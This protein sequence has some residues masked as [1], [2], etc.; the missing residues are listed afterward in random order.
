MCLFW[1]IRT[2]KL[3]VLVIKFLAL[4]SKPSFVC[5]RLGSVRS[6]HHTPALRLVPVR[7]WQWRTLEGAHGP[8]GRKRENS[9]RAV[10][11]H[12][13]CRASPSWQQPVLPAAAARSCLRFPNICRNSFMIPFS[14]LHTSPRRSF[15]LWSL[16]SC[17]TG[18]LFPAQSCQHQCGS[19][20][21]RSEF[22]L[23]GTPPLSSRTV[24]IAT[25]SCCSLSPWGFIK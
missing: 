24:I 10:P 18:P 4:P 7:L 3:P 14:A 19:T 21:E 15:Y 8:G 22:Q 2:G 11:T 5:V 6:V 20:L 16:C 23:R 12:C 9:F 1:K 17:P 25:Y 13:A